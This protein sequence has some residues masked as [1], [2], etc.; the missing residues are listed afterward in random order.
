MAKMSFTPTDTDLP[1]PPK[2]TILGAYHVPV[3]DD[4][5]KVVATERMWHRERQIL[6]YRA[7]EQVPVEELPYL[8]G[9]ADLKVLHKAGKHA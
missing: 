9:D 1:E 4:R 8:I 6:I 3:Q 5:E 2:L 7:G